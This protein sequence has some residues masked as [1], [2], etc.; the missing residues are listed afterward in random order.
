MKSLIIVDFQN[1]FCQPKGSLY[2][3]GA[4]EAKKGI[5]SY[6]QKNYKNINEIIYTKD[7][8]TTKDESFKK[9]GGIW[10]VHCVQ[11]SEG[12]EID[13]ELFEELKKYN[14]PIKIFNK[15]TVYTHEEY[16]AFENFKLKDSNNKN[17][18]KNCIFAN[19][20]NDCEINIVNDNIVVCG[21]AGDFCVMESIKNLMKHWKFNL[22][23]LV[24]GIS[25]IDGGDK[26]KNFIKEKSYKALIKVR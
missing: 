10:P 11:N 15:G 21:L 4:E 1:D 7:W 17:D 3:P 26:L 12:A 19:Y 14:I 18:I 20:G 16:G 25:S 23:I 2:V 24:S 22:E 13:K 8:H 5:I 9:N 6:I